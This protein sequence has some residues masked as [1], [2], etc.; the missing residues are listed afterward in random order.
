MSGQVAVEG[1]LRPEEESSD[2]EE[3]EEE[4]E[5]FGLAERGAE[6]EVEVPG[7]V[8]AMASSVRA[9]ESGQYEGFAAGP[10]KEQSIGAIGV[11]VVGAPVGE[12]K[13]SFGIAYQKRRLLRTVAVEEACRPTSAEEE[14]DEFALDDDA[15]GEGEQ[16]HQGAEEAI[17]EAL[18]RARLRLEAED[19]LQVSSEATAPPPEPA[20]QTH[21]SVPQ[22]HASV[23]APEPVLPR[24]VPREVLPIA[25]EDEEELLMQERSEEARELELANAARLAEEAWTH[26]GPAA[27][28]YADLEQA[29]EQT[30]TVSY[31]ELLR[32]LSSADLSAFD[33]LIRTSEE[34][35]LL[36]RVTGTRLAYPGCE[37][38]LRLPFLIAQLAYDPCQPAHAAALRTV[39]RALTGLPVSV[40]PTGPHWDDVGFQGLDPRTDINRAMKMLAVLLT[41][42]FVETHKEVALRLHSYSNGTGGMRETWPFFCVALMFT[43]QA[44][45]ALRSGALNKLCNKERSVLTPLH[46]FLC[47]SF[48][49]FE[50]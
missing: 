30:S 49:A 15:G 32:E 19:A 6:E 9:V 11:V 20:P 38:D 45:Q 43:K 22:T 29:S 39:Y 12:D 27:D 17:E 21:A 10:R 14:E 28:M 1:S 25:E 13:D 7:L 47:A 16:N 26:L 46:C 31:E 35:S 50:R 2:E 34:G 48:L 24:P 4:V 8:A 37:R 18:L 23:V 33:G 42:F 41:L 5:V 44:L 36:A 40:P 3:E